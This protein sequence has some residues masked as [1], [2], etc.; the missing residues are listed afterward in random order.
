MLVLNYSIYFCPQG[1]NISAKIAP[2]TTVNIPKKIIPS[3]SCPPIFCVIKFSILFTFLFF[4]LL[5]FGMKK[6]RK[7]QEYSPHDKTYCIKKEMRISKIS[8]Q[9]C[10]KY[11][12]HEILGNIHAIITHFLP[13]LSLPILPR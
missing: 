13:H 4:F 10:N 8:H 7:S 2:K 5:A 1:D 9:Y 12:C 11:S 3:I 6:P